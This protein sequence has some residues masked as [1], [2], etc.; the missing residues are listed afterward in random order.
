ME[1]PIEGHKIKILQNL[2][3]SGESDFWLVNINEKDYFFSAVEINV[4]SNTGIDEHSK[5]C[6]ISCSGWIQ[7]VENRLIINP[8]PTDEDTILD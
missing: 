3:C 8:F 7:V 6:Y 1:K 5:Q 2:L 4:F